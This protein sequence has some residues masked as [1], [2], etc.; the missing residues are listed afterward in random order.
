MP[1]PIASTPSP[2][3]L[4]AIIGALPKTAAHF[5]LIGCVG[6]AF[7]AANA[8]VRAGQDIK[9]ECTKGNSS[10]TIVLDFDKSIALWS[11]TIEGSV[12]EN[13]LDLAAKPDGFELRTANS[14]G[15][16]DWKTGEL[17]WAYDG[18]P[19]ASASCRRK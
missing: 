1:S 13:K 17:V 5:G 9:L 6:F 18:S 12:I 8:P 10:S 16:F 14:V 2:L 11:T 19:Y 4:T 15:T 7:C 3:R